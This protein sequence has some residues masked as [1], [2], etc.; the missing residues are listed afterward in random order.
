MTADPTL[1]ETSE[2]DHAKGHRKRLRQRFM[3]TNGQGVADYELLE[4]LLFA[5]HPR[6]DVKPLA[7]KLIKSFGSFAKVLQASPQDL[8]IIEGIGESAI[9]A[10]KVAEES[11]RRVLKDKAKQGSVISSW[12]ALLDYCRLNM[13]SKKIEEFHVLFLNHKNEIIKDEV[14]QK[15]TIDHTPVYPREIVKR[16][17]ELHASSLILAHN[18][19]SGDPTPSKADIELTKKIV[20]SARVLNISVHD[21]LI[22]GRYGQYSFKSNGLL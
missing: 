18:H 15:G 14:L 22:I 7:K 10:I 13:A 9:V 19:P 11:S 21:H 12:T 1:K 6:G 16:A 4:M 8:E 2:A 17:L 20:E 3:E 5:A